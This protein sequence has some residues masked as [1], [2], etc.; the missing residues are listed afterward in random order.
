MFKDLFVGEGFRW[1]S[2]YYIKIDEC[3]KYTTGINS[4]T[5]G[6]RNAVQL[7]NGELAYFN[8]SDIIERIPMSVEVY[9]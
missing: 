1:K 5:V 2:W 4:C 6:P 3:N 7:E 8:G 9:E